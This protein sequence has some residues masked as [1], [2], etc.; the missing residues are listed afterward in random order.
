MRIPALLTSALTLA[1]LL[2][3]DGEACAQ[4]S[5]G[6]AV[7][8]VSPLYYGP[9]AFP[10]PDLLDGTV[11]EGLGVELSADAVAGRIGGEGRTDMT[12]APTFR[13]SVPLWT[14]RA[15]FSVWGELHE[16]YSDTPATR[17]ARGLAPYSHPLRGNDSGNL[18]F[19][20]ELQVLK[21]R[22]WIP[23][24]AL[25]AVTLSATGDDS[26]I[27]RHYDAPGY[28]FDISAGKSF[29]AGESGGFRAYASAGFVCWQ[30][31][32]G[33]QNDALMLGAGLSY[34]C[35]KATFNIEYGQYSGREKKRGDE[36]GTPSGDCPRT[37]K[38]RL[39]LHFGDFSPFIHVRHGLHDWPFTQFRLGLE[40]HFDL[41]GH[42]KARPMKRN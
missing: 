13:L 28:F 20:I 25:R 38:T 15:T 8:G 16:F 1:L 19:G 27:H 14:G 36:L 40:W 17:I 34:S 41:L 22:T 26:E 33:T 11:H 7:T 18:Y 42:V 3:P 12:F 32:E 31:G 30:I 10:V 24:V 5:S 39:E 9:Y 35:G 29:A 21:E 4:E 6:P 23:A 37:L 2:P